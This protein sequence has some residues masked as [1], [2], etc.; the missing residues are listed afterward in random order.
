MTWSLVLG[1]PGSLA[2]LQGHLGFLLAA[3]APAV[4]F[5]LSVPGNRLR[6]VTWVAIGGL[7]VLAASWTLLL[8]FALVTAAYPTYVVWRRQRSAIRWAVAGVVAVTV[9]AVSL[10]LL[11]LVASPALQDLVRDGTVPKVWLPSLVVLL[12]GAAR[13]AAR[14]SS[15]G[16]AT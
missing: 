4:I 5:L 3:S 1:V 14:V 7:V 8:P 6:A 12:R 16:A 9:G 10:F 13:A 15:T 11:P 2:L